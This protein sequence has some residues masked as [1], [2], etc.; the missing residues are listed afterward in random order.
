MYQENEMGNEH[1]SALPALHVSSIET[2]KKI[3]DALALVEWVQIY[4]LRGRGL[5]GAKRLVRGFWL[6]RSLLSLRYLMLPLLSW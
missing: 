4:L 1:L 3:E 5:W 2:G 6:W